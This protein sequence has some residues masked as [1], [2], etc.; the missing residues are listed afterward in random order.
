MAGARGRRPS[1]LS[2]LP[3]RRDGQCSPPCG[4]ALRAP[5]A[6]RLRPLRHCHLRQRSPWPPAASQSGLRV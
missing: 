5:K 3:R 2:R 6:P 1:L 4:T